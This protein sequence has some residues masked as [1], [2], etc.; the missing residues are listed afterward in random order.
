MWS[1]VGV[2]SELNVDD[3]WT[4]PDPTMMSRN[5][6]NPMYFADPVGSFGTMWHPSAASFHEG[7]FKPSKEYAEL[8]NRFRYTM[9]IQERKKAWVEL[10]TYI[11]EEMPFVILYQPYESYGMRKELKWKPLPSHIP[12]V[13]DF[14]AGYISMSDR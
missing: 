9:E 1:A 14:R 8:W 5:W 13:L 10:M 3:K 11:K 12:Y 2:K 6:S 7:R 4:G